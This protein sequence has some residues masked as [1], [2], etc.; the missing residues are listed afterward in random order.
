VRRNFAIIPA[1]DPWVSRVIEKPR[2]I[3]NK[4][5]GCGIYLFALE[6]FDAI[7]RT[8]RTAMRNEYEI[9]ESI[10]I[11]IDDGH[12]VAHQNIIQE[13]LNLTVPEDLLMINLQELK[14][15]GLSNYFVDQRTL[16]EG[17]LNCVVGRNVAIGHV[18]SLRNC[19]IFDDVEIPDG[20]KIESAIVLP[21][22]TISCSLIDS[23]S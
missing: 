16:T 18:V 9:T 19:V 3:Q 4:L 13:D 22:R 23:A 20:S 14:R 10:Q 12:L 11:M 1:N 8:P 21:D 2:Y 15:L 5:K 6:I 17:V 7:R